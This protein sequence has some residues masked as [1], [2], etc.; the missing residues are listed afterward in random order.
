MFRTVFFTVVYPI[1]DI[2]SSLLCLY[3]PAEIL[4]LLQRA[5]MMNAFLIRSACLLWLTGNS[6]KYVVQIM[7]NFDVNVTSML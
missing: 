7:I 5:N 6:K 4:T 1:D 2:T 3:F